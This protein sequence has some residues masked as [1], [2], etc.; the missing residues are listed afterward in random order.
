MSTFESTVVMTIL[1][2][3]ENMTAT[4]AKWFRAGKTNSV[5]FFAML[6]TCPHLTW[7]AGPEAV[8]CLGRPFRHRVGRVIKISEVCIEE[9]TPL[10]YQS[11]CKHCEE[12]HIRNGRT[13]NEVGLGGYDISTICLLGVNETLA[14]MACQ[15]LDY[16]LCIGGIQ[17]NTR[18][19]CQ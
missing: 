6:K 14:D 10:C 19:R 7:M 16:N 1:Q 8:R 17:D 2:N 15:F 5:I 13:D 12:T 4:E 18:C 9:E 11:F 3:A